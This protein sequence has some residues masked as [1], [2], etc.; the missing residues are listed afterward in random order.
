MSRQ[1]PDGSWPQESI[2][3]G[4]FPACSRLSPAVLSRVRADGRLELAVFNKNA[5]ISYPNFKFAWSI[6]ALGQAWKKLPREGW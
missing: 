4:A 2:E 5:A 6:N 1:Q 3:G